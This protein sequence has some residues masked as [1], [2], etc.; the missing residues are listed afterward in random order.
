M[1]NAKKKIRT[2]EF[3]FPA[4]RQDAVCA[5]L[6]LIENMGVEPRR[7]ILA[8]DSAGGGLV[9]ATLVCLRERK[10]AM[11]AGLCA[12]VCHGVDR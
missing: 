11:P 2:A 10:I 6:H 7:V 4:P 8:G 9:L 5:Y 12:R 1:K 3:P